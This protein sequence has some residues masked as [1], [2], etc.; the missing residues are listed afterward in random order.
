MKES[1]ATPHPLQTVLAEAARGRFPP[2]DGEVQFVGSP[3]GPSDAVVAFT[4]H[5]IIAADVEPAEAAAHLPGDDPG[6][7]LDA[8]FLAW[9]A[10][11]LGVL[12]G[13]VD[14]VL[15]SV[16]PPSV[17][18]DHELVPATD[19][20][21]HPRFARAARY[22][23]GVQGWTDPDGRGIVILGRGLAERWEVSLEVDPAHRGRGMGRALA[24]AA[25]S[26]APAGFPLFA[27]VSPGN[28]ASVRAFLAAG[29]RPICSEVLFLR[30]DK[31]SER[32]V[33]R[34]PSV[35]R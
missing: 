23:R 21:A 32:P 8:R 1:Q 6:A 28:A 15:V 22:R 4:A 2:P 29:Y 17:G 7:P 33:D 34:G 16:D 19:L 27:Q 13:V 20:G 3:P 30:G 12:P 24:L 14:L 25:R 9:L 18:P 31:K 35:R 11:R 5:N 10:Q 26:L